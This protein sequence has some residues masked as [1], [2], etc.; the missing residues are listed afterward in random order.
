MLPGS[1]TEKRCQIGNGTWKLVII[2]TKFTYCT[3][4]TWSA[5]GTYPTTKSQSFYHSPSLL[6]E[7]YLKRSNL[8]NNAISRQTIWASHPRST[9]CNITLTGP[10][11]IHWSSVVIVNLI[12]YGIFHKQEQITLEY[13][14]VSSFSMWPLIKTI[15]TCHIKVAVPDIPEE[16]VFITATNS[17]HH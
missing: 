5:S 12:P 7:L 6:A 9:M 17:Y 11:T 15:T 1:I 3:Y 4:K 13:T 10:E 8:R 16:F 2:L 14:P